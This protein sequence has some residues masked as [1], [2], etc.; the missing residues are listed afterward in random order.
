MRAWNSSI[1]KPQDPFQD[2]FQISKKFYD[3]YPSSLVIVKVESR[4]GWN[5]FN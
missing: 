1:P 2:V 5:I 4:S 3:P